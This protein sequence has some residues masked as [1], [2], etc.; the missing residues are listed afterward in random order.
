MALFM[1]VELSVDFGTNSGEV[2]QPPLPRER[3]VHATP[4][5][6]MVV[7]ARFG[8]GVGKVIAYLISSGRVVR[9]KFLCAGSAHMSTAPA[10]CASCSQAPPLQRTRPRQRHPVRRSVF[11]PA[12]DPTISCSVIDHEQ[13]ISHTSTPMRTTCRL[14]VSHL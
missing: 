10:A 3:L 5:R 2:G 8:C 12:S 14:H 6:S 7:W 13:A 1:E 11:P 4:L 9:E